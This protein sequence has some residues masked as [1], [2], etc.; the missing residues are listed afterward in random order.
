MDTNISRLANQ[1]TPYTWAD[2]LEI[3]E[4]LRSPG[5]CPWDREQTHE[6]IRKN[7]IEETYEVVEAIDRADATLLCEELG[8]ILLQVA[9]HAQ[10]ERERGVFTVD[11]VIDGVAKKLVLR[12]PHVF[13]SVVADDSDAVLKNWDQIKKVEKHQRSQT[14]VLESVPKYFPALM[15][16]EKL[17]AKAA[18]VG[19]D[20]P[21]A[22]GALEKLDE[23]RAELAAAIREGDAAHIDE[24]LGDLLFSV[25]NVSRFLKVDS[26]ESLSRTSEK[27]IRR[28]AAMERAAAAAGKQLE[29]LSLDEM[30]KLWNDAKKQEE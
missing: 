16:A 29:Q 18:K 12:H 3:V 17:Q 7:F 2:F 9:L 23:E 30:D 26:E 19:F 15:R 14:E 22:E 25:V 20:W 13:G 5:G 28:F 27:F 6:S 21:S 24:E 11:D 1:K 10:M 4:I 8:D